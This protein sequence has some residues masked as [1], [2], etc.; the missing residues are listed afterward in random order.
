MFLPRTFL[1]FVASAFLGSAMW[2]PAG[3]AEVKVT[4]VF[5]DHMVL[6]RELAAPIYGTAAPGE[7]VTVKFRDQ[8][9]STRAGAD[10]KWVVKLDKLT[11]GGPDVLTIGTLAIKD[12]LVGDVWI[13]S[14]Q[15]NMEI[16][17]KNFVA[18]DPVLAK[19]VAAGPYPQV[20]LFSTR[21]KKIWEEAT[22]E[23]CEYFSALLFS[24]GMPLQKEIGVPVGLMSPAVGGTPSGYWLSEEAYRADAACRA[25]A[26]KFAKTYDYDA[27]KAKY[28]QALADWKTAAE[29]AKAEGK[30]VPRGPT[31]PA[32]AGES[33]GKI[34]NLYE[35]LVRPMVGFGIRGVLWD[36]GEAG[37]AIT[38]V[39][40]Y[41][42]MGALIRG[43]RQE[44][45]QG[46]FPFLYVEKPSG[47]RCAF[48]PANP[49]TEK[50]SPLAKLP[51]QVPPL[52][53]GSYRDT[54]IRIMQYPQ[55]AM[56]TS[57]DL[58]NMTHPTNKSGYGLRATRVA[59]G[60]VYG[61][62][63]EIYGPLYAS[64]QIEGDKVRLRF[65]HVGQGLAPAQ[66]EKLQGF[67]I[68]GEDQKFV[69][70]EAV[71]DGDSVVI[72]S[73]SVPKPAA[74]RY[75]WSQQIPWANLFNKDGLPAPA[76][77]TD[78]WDR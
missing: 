17:S 68:A 67:A 57:S 11:A 61:K 21:G 8:E 43:W 31:V 30:P 62:K 7:E 51:A 66:A 50:A 10:G 12:V 39:D 60:F 48:D 14:G 49:V 3:R 34:G 20:R 26:E 23:T 36:Q 35:A 1:R 37:T 54:H 46:E 27:A 4:P 59:L 73:A 76:F 63:I 72:S 56:V 42:L 9:K 22:P 41:T 13:G 6:Q 32:K 25:A 29:A 58:G 33:P 5:G 75:A 53:A 78:A 40:Q 28:D 70:A 71:I 64:H 47:E 77:R 74:V 16:A 65:T 15:S 55:T 52:S 2:L 24:F 44:W 18:G 45:G 38:G 69:W 19:N